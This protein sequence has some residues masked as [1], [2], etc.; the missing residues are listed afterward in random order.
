MSGGRDL[1]SNGVGGCQHCLEPV[2][3]S[4]VDFSLHRRSSRPYK[5]VWGMGVAL[6]GWVS[7]RFRPS[8]MNHPLVVGMSRA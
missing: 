8:N 3:G 4:G 5:V 7:A 2:A 6:L 1:G